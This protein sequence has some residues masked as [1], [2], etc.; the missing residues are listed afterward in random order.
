MHLFSLL[1]IC[2]NICFFMQRCLEHH[3][4]FSYVLP[5][6]L[7]FFL[8][9]LQYNMQF[10]VFNLS[11]LQS[12]GC[13]KPSIFWNILFYTYLKYDCYFVK[14]PAGS[15]LTVT[16]FV[17]FLCGMAFWITVM[18]ASFPFSLLQL[19]SISTLIGEDIFM[20][21]TSK[22]LEPRDLDN[23]IIVYIFIYSL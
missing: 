13:I 23:S 15:D 12:Q 8:F 21:L 6:R 10:K 18:T 4:H 20:C 17:H 5:S 3:L 11:D 2:D 16:S 19:P 1:S 9:C 14:T 7:Y 22:T